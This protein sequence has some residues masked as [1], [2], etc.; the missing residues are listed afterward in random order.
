VLPLGQMYHVMVDDRIPYY[1]YG[2]RQDGPSGAG[3]SN[4][5]LFELYGQ[6]IG[7][8]PALWRTVGGGESG[9]ATPD[10]VDTNLVWSTASG[11]G[12]V[13]GIVTQY[14]WATNSV[15]EVEVWPN[16]TTGT[17]AGDVK[18]RF[19]WTFPLTIS[20]FDHNTVYVG[21]QYIHATTDGGKNW[22]IIS[23][24][25][26]RNDKPRL[27][28]SGGLTPDNIGVEYSGVVFAISESPKEKGLI[29]A[30]TNDGLVHLTRDGGKTWTNLTANIPGMLG[31]GTVGNIEA[32]RWDAGTAYI[33]VDGHQVNNRDPWI[34][35]TTD[36]GKTWK[37][38]TNGIPKSPLSY[39][40]VVREDPVR[41]GLL[42]AGTENGLYVSFDDGDHWQSF[43]SDLP[44]APVYWLVVQERFS[45]L[46][47]ATYGR[48]FYIVDDIS[49]LRAMSPE[50]A[51]KDAHLF[52]PRDAYRFRSVEWPFVSASEKNPNY[53]ET[54]P[55]GVPFDFWTASAA[56]GDSATISIADASGAVVRTMKVAAKRGLN[57]AWWNFR[58]DPTVE[59]RIRVSPRYAPW[60]AIPAQG[61]PTPNFPQFALLEPPGKY[62]VTLALNGK[63]ESQPLTVLKDPAS[64]SSEA[65]IAEQ[66]TL[67]RSIMA[68][69]DVAAGLVNTLEKTRAQLAVMRAQAG[70]DP[71]GTKHRAAIDS[72]DQKLLDV[73]AELRN[74]L[75]TGRGQDML[76]YPAK[77]CEKLIYLAGTLSNSDYAPTASQR[78][79]AKELHDQLVAMKAQIDGLMKTDVMEFHR[80]MGASGNR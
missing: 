30:G 21:S 51:A 79:V 75:S 13:G 33:S 68:D 62:T 43:Q 69:I 25:L 20:P 80:G 55:E 50:V 31:W 73:E 49:P 58:S 74:V 24:D 18:Y 29:W 10:P 44:H 57:R 19:V 47:I 1:I 39:V 6:S 14:N 27:G 63:T 48:G 52:K 34:F 41:K 77:L 36:Y 7:I 2:N 15:H 67:L 22:S 37:Q 54:A 26:T 23:P 16:A 4:A 17:P 71:A 38:I 9:W 46:V 40:H 70:S 61:I 66:M 42:Y 65:G 5:K 35:K 11:Y 72:L 3:P 60:M 45:D 53:G 8:P 78:A 32:S 12:S 76:R 64:G 59:S 56:K 28:I